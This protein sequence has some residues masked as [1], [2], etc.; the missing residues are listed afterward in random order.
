MKTF[1]G[2]EKYVSY[3]YEEGEGHLYVIDKSIANEVGLI[4]LAT[5]TI[6]GSVPRT[7]AQKA[8]LLG[9]TMGKAVPKIASL[10][11]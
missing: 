8:W 1:Y 6:K 10:L 3:V 9:P 5:L 11:K 7:E 4:D 2:K